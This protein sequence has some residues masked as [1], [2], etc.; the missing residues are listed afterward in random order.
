[1]TERGPRRMWLH[2]LVGSQVVT[3][4]GRRLGRVVDFEV[5]H[6]AGFEVVALELGRYGV[7]DR[8]AV[9]AVVARLVGQHRPRTVQWSS[10][11]VVEDGTIR[12]VAGAPPPGEE[13][14]EPTGPAEGRRPVSDR[15][16]T[17]TRRGSR[18][19]SP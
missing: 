13:G 11:D 10:V 5:A 6:D 4:D 19:E 7:F 3:A 18:S 15:P 16:D 9:T 14:A 1:M 12:L 17:R 2:D 8:L